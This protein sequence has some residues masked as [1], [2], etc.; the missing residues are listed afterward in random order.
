MTVCLLLTRDTIYWSHKSEEFSWNNPVEIT[1]FNLFVVFILLDVE[2]SEVVPLLLESKLETLKTVL[3]SALIEA[4][5][6]ACVTIASEKW[7]IWGKHFHN[8]V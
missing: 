3:H 1:V 6:L 5:T 4:V 8:L 2:F 7:N